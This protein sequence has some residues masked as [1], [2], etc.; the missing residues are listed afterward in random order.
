MGE[1][2]LLLL[3]PDAV[4][5]RRIG[6]RVIKNL[7]G[8]FKITGFREGRMSRELAERFYQVHKGKFFYPSLVEYVTSGPV[9]ALILEGEDVIRRVRGLLGATKPEEAKEN[10]I[11]GRYG[12]YGGINVAH[13]SDSPESS[14]REL[15]LMREMFNLT[16]NPA[17]SEKAR[18]YV[19]RFDEPRGPDYTPELRKLSLRLAGNEGLEQEIRGELGKLLKEENP[20]LDREVL[21]MF[22]DVIIRNCVQ[23]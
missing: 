18:E 1:R 3:K 17:A 5:R 6:A 22:L 15:A 20:D 11:R 13:A 16:E 4:I 12:I 19:A 2:T 14:R 10:T 21:E 8:R 23:K 9:V 7:L